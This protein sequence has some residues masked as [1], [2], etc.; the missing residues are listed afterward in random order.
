ML[1]F[2]VNPDDDT[3]IPIAGDPQACAIYELSKDYELLLTLINSGAAIVCFVDHN[4]SK[5]IITRDVAM[6]YDRNYRPRARGISYGPM[7][8]AN[9]KSLISDFLKNCVTLNL[10]FIM[11]QKKVNTLMPQ[12][13]F[14]DPKL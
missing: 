13:A 9:S 4:W 14:Q 11:P 6:L 3:L 7:V 2:Q 12:A 10:E 1:A 5:N 8:D